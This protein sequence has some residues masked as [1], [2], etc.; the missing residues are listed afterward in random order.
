MPMTAVV[1]T[2]TDGDGVSNAVLAER[3]DSMGHSLNVE[4]GSAHREIASARRE[5]DIAREDRFA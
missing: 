2:Q 5:N 4:I 3:L 1:Q